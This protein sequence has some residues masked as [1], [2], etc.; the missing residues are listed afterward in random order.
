ML[1]INMCVIKQKHTFV[2]NFNAYILKSC[3]LI[4]MITAEISGI[5]NRFRGHSSQF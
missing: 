1:F 3:P 4:K 2:R 5:R